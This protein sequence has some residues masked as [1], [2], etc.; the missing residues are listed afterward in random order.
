MPLCGLGGAA[1][2]YDD[3]AT[4]PDGTRRTLQRKVVVC[5]DGAA[6][7]TS[8]LNVFVNGE[9]PYVYE[10]TVFE[11]HVKDMVVDSTALEMALWDTAGQE[12]FDKLR[13]LSYADTHIVMLCFSVDI[14]DSLENVE[15][16]WV[17]EITLHVPGVKI[18]LVACKCDLREDPATKSRLAQ[19]NQRPVQYDDGLAVAKRIRASRYL[20]QLSPRLRSTSIA[21]AVLTLPSAYQ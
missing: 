4:I 6:G 13:S 11:N 9:F 8:L 14:P 15:S 3:Q 18:C 5:G 1:T 12:D 21:S 7:K 10:P 16:K 17:E 19:Y 2:G 20:G